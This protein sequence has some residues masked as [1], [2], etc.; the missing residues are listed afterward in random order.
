MGTTRR[1][2]NT[3]DEAIARG[4]EAARDAQEQ[5]LYQA[6]L[7]AKLLRAATLAID[8]LPGHCHELAGLDVDRINVRLRRWCDAVIEQLRR[9]SGEQGLDVRPQCRKAEP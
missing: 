8:S 1:K 5:A 7:R 3:I 9:A 6:E 2:P 4:I